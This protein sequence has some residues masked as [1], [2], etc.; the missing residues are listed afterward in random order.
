MTN[1]QIAQKAYADFKAGDIP[2]ILSVMTDDIELITPGAGIPTAGVR[3]GK[4][5]VARFFELVGATWDFEAFE[6]R[7]YVG[8]GE[9][10]VAIGSYTAMARATGRKVSS[11]WAMLWK[12][13]DGKATYFREFTDTLALSQAVTPNIASHG[14]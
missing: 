11:D 2:S 6:P 12:F 7:E 9:T 5:E 10:V 1:I 13:R 4:A 8:S 14:A 3:H